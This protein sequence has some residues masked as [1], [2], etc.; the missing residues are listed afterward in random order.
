[1]SPKFLC[2]LLALIVVASAQQFETKTVIDNFR[3]QTGPLVVVV[4]DGDPTP[5]DLFTSTST[6]GVLGG[7]RDLYLRVDQGTT[8]ISSVVSNDV[9]NVAGNTGISGI[10]Y[11]QYD[12]NDNS[13]D[14]NSGGLGGIDLTSNNGDRIRVT[15]ESQI[16]TTF[17]LLIEDM[18]GRQSVALI[19]VQ[20]S[21]NAADYDVL[22][23]SDFNGNADFSNVGAIQLEVDVG[24]QVDTVLSFF[25]VIGPVSS[26]SSRTPTRTRD[27]AASPSRTPVPNPSESS[28]PPPQGN[29]FTWY[30]FDDDDDGRSPCG[31]EHPRKT[32]FVSDDNIIYYYF[33]G[34]YQGQRYAVETGS[35]ASVLSVCFS[36]IA[37][38]V[39]FII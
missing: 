28:T 27:P 19:D 15:I 13:E 12:G 6:N 39:A 14:I 38:I 7:E 20:D 26:T 23:N 21:D 35:P 29:G 22:F 24:E 5:E 25:A 4:E 8:L 34:A 11:L 36:L 18:S 3:D 30:T 9:W 37:T 2:V 32:Y 33:F 31:D 1:M 10:T 17:T 16:D